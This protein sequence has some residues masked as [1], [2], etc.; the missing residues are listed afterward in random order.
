MK[1]K[2]HIKIWIRIMAYLMA[3]N[4]IFG[5]SMTSMATD[6]SSDA[7][8]DEDKT[9]LTEDANESE[10]S[11]E[12]ETESSEE[13]IPVPIED[14][15]TAQEELQEITEEK[16]ILALVYLCDKYEIKDSPSQDGH[17][18]VSVKSGQ[19]VQIENVDMD[20][21]GGIWYKVSLYQNEKSYTGYIEEKYLAT[22]DEVFL[23]WTDEYVEE[24]AEESQANKPM[25]MSLPIMTLS[26]YPDVNQFPASY[27]NALLALKQKY[28]NWTFV[29]METALDFNTAVSKELGEK[30]WISSSQPASWKNGATK[31][32]GWSYA[33]EGILRYYMD[34]R[35]FLA[36]SSIF[37]F[38]QLT[39]NE[40]YHTESAVQAIV[41]NSFMSGDIPSEDMTYAGAFTKIGKELKISP[42]H[43]AS[44]VLQEQG[45]KGTSPLISGT[46]TGYEGYYNYFNVGASGSTYELIVKGLTEA[47]NRGWDTR[48]KSLYGGAS[49]IGENYILRGQDTL[50]LQKFN[51]SSN[52]TYEHQYMQNI[53]APASE[54]P[55]IKKAY[56]DTGALNNSFVF[57]IPVYSNMPASACSKPETIDEITLSKSSISSL[58]VDKTEKLIPYVNGSKVDNVK[59][60]SFSSNNT[61]VA[62]VDGQGVVKAIS[63][64]TAKITCARSG[65][66]SASCTVTVV[67]AEPVVDTPVLSPIVY[68]EGLKLS[69][70]DLPE[71]WSWSNG[72]TTL[73]AGT[74]SYP[75]VYTPEDTTR[76]LTVTR[77]IGLK[78]TRTI[79]HCDV[80]ENLTA[81]L[82]SKLGSISLPKGFAWESDE[83]TILD[84]AGEQTYYLSYYPSDHNY[85]ELMHIPVVV[86]VIDDRTAPEE[87]DDESGPLPG[88]ND[89]KGNAGGNNSS[90]SGSSG[91]G[92][93]GTS[94]GSGNN[95]G[96]NSDSNSGGSGSGS[97][98]GGNSSGSG[99]TG[100][101]N[102][103]SDEDSGSS[104]STGNNNPGGSDSPKND[105]PTTDGSPKNDD[106]KS[107]GPT[108]DGSSG[109]KKDD[110]THNNSNTNSSNHDTNS[111]D[112]SNNASNADSDGGNASNVSDTDSGSRTD[113]NG[114]NASNAND[115]DSNGDNA[116]NVNS[117][118]SSSTDIS[119]DNANTVNNA[120]SDGGHSDNV[121]DTQHGTNSD[122]NQTGNNT[123]GNGNT[124]NTNNSSTT[125]NGNTTHTSNNAATNSNA[126]SSNADLLSE[127][128]SA[129]NITEPVY[130]RPSIMMDMEDVSILTEEILQMAKE[131]NIDLVL[132]MNNRAKWHVNASAV[133]DGFSDIDMNV[134]FQNGVIPQELLE[135]KAG[136]S[137]YLEF[138]LAH[139]GPFGFSAE[140]EIA[141]NPED[142]GRYANLFYFD[143]EAVTL[144]FICAS[145]IDENGYARFSMEHASSYVIIIS[146]YPMTDIASSGTESGFR[147]WWVLLGVLILTVL[148]GA[149]Y[150]GYYFWRKQQEED[151][152][153][154]EDDEE[155]EDDLED[156]VADEEYEDDTAEINMEDDIAA[157]NMDVAQEVSNTENAE[158]DW[159]EDEDWQEPEKHEKTDIYAD[160][161]AEDDWI[162]DDEWD[163]SN[164]W[165]EDDEWEKKRGINKTAV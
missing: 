71:G 126:L 86:R 48:Y 134:L 62:T 42:F 137:E 116:S 51:V 162:E 72:D 146:D 159:I 164:D 139:D 3:V 138:S 128:A 125:N 165:M 30:S 118:E 105:D 141:L 110:T 2:R 132:T 75:A 96:G 63:P 11:E 58:A 160:D 36:E 39:Y 22:S 60:M 10:E 15:E 31:Q 140:L 27:Q 100:G 90:S 130:E 87:P 14:L 68:K 163:I 6:S 40:S 150:G 50:Y 78:V 80:P 93:S 152:D 133:T 144:D 156:V 76:Y 29:K 94:G 46:Y 81:K 153:E 49:V 69:D 106:D 16:S 12:T 18:V 149:G 73:T 67:K 57:K 120:G 52:R 24:V 109:K 85:F 45:A 23:E 145:I 119:G 158:D 25:T 33:S 17:G 92:G 38:E 19:T 135:D 34:P 7:H 83:E 111:G 44:R 65:A 56:S 117:V 147:A 99:N 66:A 115:T 37:Q 104:G 112:N 79:P 148:V 54:A 95:S 124:V 13:E 77:Q 26:N 59:D 154:D 108:A 21:E 155:Y 55:N 82:G 89:D 114:G 122:N 43:L 142:C 5:Q 53:M 103:G 41:A 70:V 98:S 61:S 35:N 157:H 123:A 101:D 107:N 131:Q 121:S 20:E 88:G 102:A 47:K 136:E 4:V 151:G 32:S 74:D 113:G 64:G 28:P 127:T 143:S 1:K 8:V 129:E 161:H 97:S 91:S 9:G 84:K